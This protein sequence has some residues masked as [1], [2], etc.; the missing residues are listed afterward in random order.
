VALARDDEKE[1][2]ALGKVVIEKENVSQ[3]IR[4]NDLEK[5]SGAN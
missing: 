5:V 4:V 1:E 2:E 3:N